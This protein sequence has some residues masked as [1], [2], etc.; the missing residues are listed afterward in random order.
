MG[1]KQINKYTC[2]ICNNEKSN[3]TKP[4]G[5]VLMSVENRYV[6]RSFDDKCICDH[7]LEDILIQVDV[8]THA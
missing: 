6:D 8:L 4:D 2:D 5:W 1:V 3:P 7:C